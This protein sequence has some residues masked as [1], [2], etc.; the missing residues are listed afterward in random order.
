MSNFN[1]WIPRLILAV[2][3]VHF[4]YGFLVESSLGGIA[5]DGFVNAVGD[6]AEREGWM[7]FMLAGA[8]LAAIGFQA[9]R[10]V[11]DHGRVPLGTGFWMLGIGVP[12]AVLQPASGSWLLIALGVA[13]LVAAR[14]GPAGGSSAAPGRRSA[15]VPR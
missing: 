8:G 14:G 2:T 12:L 6:D 9:R 15:E 10:A 13:A 3:A 7:W 11:L 5:S 1:R 4:G